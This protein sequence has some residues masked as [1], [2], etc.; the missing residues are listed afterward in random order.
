MYIFFWPSAFPVVMGAEE[1]PQSSG[2]L[3][4]L[5]ENMGW[6]SESGPREKQQV[7]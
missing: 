7:P 5:A 1:F 2:A 6:E 4:A 3:V